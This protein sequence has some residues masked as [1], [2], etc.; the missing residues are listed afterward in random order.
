MVLKDALE[1]F[2]ITQE[3]KGNSKRTLEYYRLNLGYFLSYLGYDYPVCNITLLDLNNFYLHLKK[4]NVSTVTLQ[5]YIRAL[6]T[7][8]NWCYDEEYISIKLTDRFRLP[9]AEKKVF[10]VLTDYEI[11]VLFKCFNIKKFLELRNW[12]IC[13]LM[14]DCGLRK[15]EVVTMTLS[16]YRG[17]D[18][19][20]IVQ[21]KGNCQRIVP[22]GLRTRKHMSKYVALRPNQLNDSLF[23]QKD[24]S[25]ITLNVIKQLF[26]RLKHES[27]IK[28]LHPH[29]LRHTF[30]TRFIE[31]GGDIFTLQQLLGHTTLD[32]SKKYLHLGVSNTLKKYK[33]FSP[34]DNMG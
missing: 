11:E 5:T 14:L 32:M 19:Y 17:T 7:F 34:L 28:R 3:I 15:N 10:D 18:G 2:L 25:P 12:C 30:A 24:Y 22:M 9:K 33:A 31:N 4:R 1:L 26:S 16:R 20:I 8:L 6:R 13:A 23:L 29:L 27:G 21:G